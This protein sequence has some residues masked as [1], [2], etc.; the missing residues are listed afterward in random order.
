M[1]SRAAVPT[2]GSHR[3]AEQACRSIKRVAAGVAL[4]AL[5]AA[6]HGQGVHVQADEPRAFGYQV[7][8]TVQRHVT[9]T[10]GAGWVL[11]DSS[12][13]R[14]GAR[15]GALE[16]RHLTARAQAADG[17]RRHEFDLQYQVFISPP[18][19][20]TFEIPSFRLRFNGPQRSEEVLVEAWP[21]TVAP[22]VPTEASPRRGLGELRPDVAPAPIDDRAL[23][24]RLTGWAV[25]ALL[26]SG[27]LAWI[28]FGPPWRA[29]RSRPFG[30]AWRQLRRLPSDAAGVPW[31]EACKAFH[32]ALNRCAGEVVFEHGLARFVAAQPAFAPLRD[33]LASFLQR[34]RDEFFGDAALARGDAAWLVALCRR[35][36]D[37]ERGFAVTGARADDAV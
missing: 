10:A 6:A 27:A 35:C 3:S 34:S 12:L 14:P 30:Q 32:H 16:L 1:S 22:L 5:Q 29:A 20:R 15:G 28:Q 21:V 23:R 33:D 8:D 9:V 19:V 24:L 11:D 36:R 37:A 18:A 17:G 26:L 2:R 4:V 31:R 7:G 13:P 25:A